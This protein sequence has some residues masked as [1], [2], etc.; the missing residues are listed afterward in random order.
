MNYW[1]TADCHFGH[2]RMIQYATRPFKDVNHMNESLIQRWND[3]VGTG[4]IVFHLGD[5]TYISSKF[6]MRSVINR[7]NGQIIFVRGNHDHNNSLETPIEDIHM[8]FGGKNLLLVHDPESAIP[9][10]DLVL[11]GHVHDLFRYRTYP[12]FE[13]SYDVCNVGV[14]AWDFHPIKINEILSGYAEWVKEGKWSNGFKK[15]REE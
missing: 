5:F 13:A 4:D 11:C 15:K 10:Y 7:L 6:D 12:Y 3:R 1:F 8:I 9:G 2:E 14:D